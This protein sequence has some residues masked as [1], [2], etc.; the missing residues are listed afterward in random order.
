MNLYIS[1]EKESEFMNISLET[2]EKKIKNK[3]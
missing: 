2:N 3:T 1:I